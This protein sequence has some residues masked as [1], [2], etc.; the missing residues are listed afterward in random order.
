VGYGEDEGSAIGV[1]DA[2]TNK[3]LDDAGKLDSHPESFQIESSGPRIFVNIA[4]K[5]KI[6]VIDR[7]THKVID[8]QIGNLKANF[9]MA[10]DEAD[11]RL[12]IGTRKPSRLGIIDTTTGRLIASLQAAGDM[13]DL[14]YDESRKRI[15]IPGGEGFL[16]V[17]EQRDPDHY[18]MLAKIPSAIGA[19]T[20]VWFAK[21][22]R[23]YLAVPGRASQGAE[24][25][26]Y[27]AQ[28]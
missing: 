11:R 21:R 15:Y 20:G 2:V 18:E 24:V 6:A 23:L 22:D 26:V 3:R 28:D 16:S 7:Q 17:Y 19:R 14:Y 9:P 13:D 8:W 12:F 10:L 4:S 1:V 5:Q 27:E 25:W